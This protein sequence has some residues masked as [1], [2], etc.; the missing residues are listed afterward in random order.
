MRQFCGR[1]E[2]CVLSAGK[3]HVHKILVLGGGRF[4]V[5]G[6]GGKCRFYF[7]G[8]ADFSEISS[9]VGN[10][11]ETNGIREISFQK[12]KPRNLG[13]TYPKDPAVLKIVR[14][15][16]SLRVVFLVRRGDLLSARLVRTPFS[17]ELQTFF[18][19]KKGPRRTN[20]GGVVKP[21]RRSNSLVL[22]LS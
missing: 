12:S 4:W 7:Y 15:V 5:W 18:L 13:E 21:L 20:L 3:T 6:G 1:L 11:F 22:L 14:V 8:R 19:S 9:P 16:N 2:K 10:H 17:W